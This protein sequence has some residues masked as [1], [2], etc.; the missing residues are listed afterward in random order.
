MRDIL[1][2]WLTAG[3]LLFMG[4]PGPTVFLLATGVTTA[5]HRE[6]PIA[7][8]SDR[9]PLSKAA[10]CSTLQAQLTALF[11]RCYLLSRVSVLWQPLTMSLT[12]LAH[13]PVRVL[14]LL[15]GVSSTVLRNVR[16]LLPTV[17][18]RCPNVRT[19]LLK[20]LPCRLPRRWT[21][22][23]W[24]PKLLLCRCRCALMH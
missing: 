19:P 16:I 21:V 24:S 2:V 1:A 6:F 17:A 22:P 4:I 5:E 20:V 15:M 9:H 14:Q 23:K 13:V 3:K 11:S 18:L 10:R 12:W 7:N 8:Y